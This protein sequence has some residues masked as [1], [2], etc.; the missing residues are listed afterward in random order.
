MCG[1]GICEECHGVFSD[2]KTVLCFECAEKEVANNVQLVE[3]HKR[4]TKLEYTIIGVGSVIGLIFGAFLIE[5]T[6]GLS[7]WI[8]LGVGANIW[9]IGSR[10]LSAAGQELT[11][12]SDAA[13]GSLWGALGWLLLGWFSGPIVPIVRIRKRVNQVRQCDEI[14]LNDSSFLSEMRDYF[15][16]SQAMEDNKGANLTDLVHQGSELYDNAYAKAVMQK[17]ER[18]AQIEL[19][20]GAIHIA[21]NGEIIRSFS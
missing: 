20:R 7:L 17:G 4:K 19:R 18:T 5:P 8:G 3:E 13:E 1:N 21:A 2:S 11:G 12:N 6:G 10:L 16:Y 15:A 14:I 9:V